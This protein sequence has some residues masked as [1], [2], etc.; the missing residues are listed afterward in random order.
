[1]RPVRCGR[2]DRRSS[3]S[4]LDGREARREVVGA[5]LD[6][7]GNRDA[8]FAIAIKDRL[9]A[10]DGEANDSL[11]ARLEAKDVALGRLL[12]LRLPGSPTCK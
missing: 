10:Q 9:S 3:A 12:T 1:M 7:L 5:R 11:G 8:Q 4:K 6:R 2:F